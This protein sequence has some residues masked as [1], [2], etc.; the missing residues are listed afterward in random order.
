MVSWRAGGGGSRLL[1]ASELRRPLLLTLNEPRSP[2]RYSAVGGKYKIQILGDRPML[3]D[4]LSP[5]DV[6][7]LKD[8]FETTDENKSGNIDMK[9]ELCGCAASHSW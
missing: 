1:T 2:V 9:G 7:R 3:H 5:P 8:A 6:T 4:V